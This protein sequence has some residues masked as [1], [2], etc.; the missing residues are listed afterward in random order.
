MNKTHIKI[1]FSDIDGTL[2]NSK[3]Q[4]PAN[5]GYMIEELAKRDIIF[6][7]ASGRSAV[8]IMNKLGEHYLADNVYIVSDNGAII[9]HKDRI[10]FQSGFEKDDLHEIIDGFQQLDDATIAAT[11]AS[12]SYVQSDHL[13]ENPKY[14]TEYFDDFE[15]IDDLKNIPHAIVNISSHSYE[16]TSRNF[17][18]E[19]LTKLREK[20]TIVQTG[21]Q[22]ID[23]I[24]NNTN[25][26]VA[27]KAL[28]EKLGLSPDNVIAF[29]D[30]NNDIQMLQIAKK[31]YAMEAATDEVIAVADEIIGSNDDNSVVT[32]ILELLEIS[33]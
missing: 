23:A 11:T 10:I 20:H 8:S 25:K 6:V 3:E 15:L 22:W 28:T 5:F 31:G 12:I 7:A 1:I 4:L 18:S 24:P 26:G 9:M 33:Q 19:Q 29:G 17:N 16:H 27:V 32:K 30:Y 13:I 2:I 14:L 21:A